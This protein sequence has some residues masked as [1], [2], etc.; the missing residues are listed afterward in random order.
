[1]RQRAFGSPV[2][3]LNTSADSKP[4]PSSIYPPIR[5]VQELRNSSLFVV[6]SIVAWRR[7]IQAKDQDSPQTPQIFSPINPLPP[8]DTSLQDESPDA[9]PK[10][11]VLHVFFRWRDEN[12]LLKMISDMNFVSQVPQILE[13]LP[14]KI[15]ISRNPFL[16]QYTLDDLNL[17]SKDSGTISSS[18]DLLRARQA[19]RLILMEEKDEMQ[20]KFEEEEKKGEAKLG[21]LHFLMSLPTCHLSPLID[22]SPPH[23]SPLKQVFTRRGKQQSHEED[24]NIDTTLSKAPRL[25]IR[26]LK[27]F[28]KLSNPPLAIAMVFAC[29][30]ILVRSEKEQVRVCQSQRTSP[31]LFR[32]A[33]TYKAV[34]SS[35]ECSVELTI[36]A[37]RSYKGLLVNLMDYLQLVSLHLNSPFSA[38]TYEIVF[39]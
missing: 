1:M 19:A 13:V 23:D 28:S 11:K 17:M 18:V 33:A 14:A 10:R 15:Q 22:A 9:A 16:L 39:L 38:S 26:E 29:V 24:V 7:S 37:L 21:R 35:E 32:E 25:N 2:S 30:K 4:S 20:R 27:V 34:F 5:L 8:I 31:V 36:T 6:E 3:H 12:Y